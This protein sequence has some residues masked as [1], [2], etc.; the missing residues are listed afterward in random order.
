MSEA[1]ASHAPVETSVDFSV[2]TQTA[3]PVNKI[4]K[5]FPILQRIINGKPL[6]YM[7]NAASAQKPRNVIEAVN[8]FYCQH[9][10][11]VHRGLHTLSEEATTAYEAARIKLQHFI[12]A[13]SEREVIYTRGTTE[14]INLVAQSYARQVLKPGDEV[15]IS[16]MEHHSNIVPWQIVCRQTGAVLKVAPINDAGEMDM[17]GFE[18]ALS[19]RTKLV[20]IAHISNALGTINPVRE[21]VTKAHDVGAVVL[22]DG[23]QAVP[24]ERVDVQALDC[25]FYAF[26]GHKMFGPTGIGLLYGKEH[27][28]DAMPPYQGGGD[29]IKTVTF[30]ET[31]YN[32]LPFKFEAGTPNIA[33][34]IGFG[35]AVDYLLE[36]GLDA[37]AEYEHRLL[38]YGTE[39]LCAIPGL[40]MIGTAQQKTSVLS[41]IMEDAHPHD[42]G[43]LLAQQGLAVRTG[44]HC[45]QPVMD[46]FNVP[47]TTRA[48]LALYNTHEEIDALVAGLH[49]VREIFGM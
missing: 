19:E 3:F 16:A 15:L 27:L 17:A 26:S 30:T 42:V 1:T 38:H 41:F 32:D 28:L 46:H 18:A 45:A 21:V 49:K 20:A 14:S 6:I 9:N 29:M 8:D 7:D 23:A 11:N 48:S 31:I 13:A 33:G 24:H 22:L 40:T 36:V 35:A 44:H 12:N 5:D 47:A 2:E 4:R 43:T 37:I 39:Q 10:S 25:D 34:A